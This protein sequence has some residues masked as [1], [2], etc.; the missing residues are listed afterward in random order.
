MK[1][2]LNPSPNIVLGLFSKVLT[3]S[4]IWRICRS[5][6]STCLSRGSIRITRSSCL[7]GCLMPQKRK[8]FIRG[9]C[10]ARS[11]V[12]NCCK[13]FIFSFLKFFVKGEIPESKDC[14]K[15]LQK[16][17]CLTL[18]KLISSSNNSSLFLNC[19]SFSLKACS[20]FFPMAYF[21]TL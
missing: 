8:S 2:T 20:N 6:I 14:L 3:R 17:Q 19:S 1:L 9:R 18:I 5:T 21:S 4:C 7:I 13:S 15:L 12:F 10:L 11:D 16:N